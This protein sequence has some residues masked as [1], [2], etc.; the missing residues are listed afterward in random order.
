MTYSQPTTLSKPVLFPDDITIII[1][2]PESEYLQ[3]CINELFTQLNGWFKA[4]KLTLNC[5]QNKI[6]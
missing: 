6:H 3:I 4:N 2:H 5:L 1:Y